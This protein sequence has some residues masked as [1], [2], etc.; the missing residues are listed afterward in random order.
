MSPDARAATRFT[1]APISVDHR[2]DGERAGYAAGW[3]AGARAA[4]EAAAEAEVRRAEDARR[5]QAA[6][7]DQVAAAVEVLAQAAARL[8]SRAAADE[9]HLRGVLQA[10]ALELAEAVLRRELRT[11]PESA[12]ELLARALAMTDGAPGAVLHVHPADARLVAEAGAVLPDGVT[13]VGDPRLAP[14]DVV[15]EDATGALDGRIRT[16][17]ER[18]RAALGEDLS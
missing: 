1:P 4:A 9:A 12:R 15:V 7:D 2:V 14:G 5:A 17:L 10:A 18:A 11:G 8:A 16:A 6:R 3:V 13:L